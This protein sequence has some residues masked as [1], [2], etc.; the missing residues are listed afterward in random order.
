MLPS[1]LRWNAAVNGERQS[2][3]AEAMGKAGSDP[4]DLLSDFISSLGLPRSLEDVGVPSE[5][6][7]LIARKVMHDRWL[8]TNPRKIHGPEEIVEIL[9]TAK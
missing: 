8:H 2:L 5:Q 1:V 3:V 7:E 4:S 9:Q 6:F